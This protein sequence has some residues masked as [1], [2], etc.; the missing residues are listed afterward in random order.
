MGTFRMGNKSIADTAVELATGDILKRDVEMIRVV[1][2]DDGFVY[3]VDNRRLAVF[4][5]LHMRKKTRIVKARVVAKSDLQKREWRKKFSTQTNGRIIYVTGCG[6]AVKPSI[7]VTL[8]ETTYPFQLLE[9]PA[10]TMIHC[11]HSLETLSHM[12][13]DDEDES[14]VASPSDAGVKRR[15]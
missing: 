6:G 4:R 13:S 2:H 15:R 7:G 8:D 3:S 1:E 11:K 10:S 12:E 14:G 5:L 9:Q